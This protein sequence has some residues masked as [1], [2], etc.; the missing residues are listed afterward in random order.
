MNALN[1]FGVTYHQVDMLKSLGS[2]RELREFNAQLFIII[3]QSLMTFTHTNAT[4][5]LTTDKT[6]TAWIK[7]LFSLDSKTWFSNKCRFFFVC[8][9]YIQLLHHIKHPII[10]IIIISTTITEY[11][12]SIRFQ[13]SFAFDFLPHLSLCLVQ[14]KVCSFN[15]LRN[16]DLTHTFSLLYDKKLIQKKIFHNMKQYF[17]LKTCHLTPENKMINF[18]FWMKIIFFVENETIPFFID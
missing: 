5:A 6:R 3:L 17:W 18:Y 2:M 15:S 8:T 14:I 12:C 7:S 4:L 1:R 10:I 16:F 13:L 9:L 11:F